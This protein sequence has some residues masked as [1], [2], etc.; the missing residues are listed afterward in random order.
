MRLYVCDLYYGL[1]S[2]NLDFRKLRL[3]FDSTNDERIIQNIEINQ[4][5]FGCTKYSAQA[6]F[7]RSLRTLCS[8]QVPTRER[9]CSL[10]TSLYARDS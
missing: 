2:C 6:F 10:A 9:V 5:A 8:A 4:S 3:I 1:K 7:I